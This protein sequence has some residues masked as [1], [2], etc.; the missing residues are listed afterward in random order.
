[1][2]MNRRTPSR[3]VLR[4][5]SPARPTVVTLLTHIVAA[6]FTS[7]MFLILVFGGAIITFLY[8]SNVS[9]DNLMVLLFGSIIVTAFYRGCLA[10]QQDLDD[11]RSYK[12]DPRHTYK[13]KF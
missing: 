7:G 5:Q 8:Y 6:A 13:S 4:R 3:S 9:P 10:W 11:Y 12:S 2:R 1:M